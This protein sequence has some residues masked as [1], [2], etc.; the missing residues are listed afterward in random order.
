M[1]KATISL[2][3]I[4]NG[5]WN[6]KTRRHI[7]M[8]MMNGSESLETRKVFYIN[9]FSM[10]KNCCTKQIYTEFVPKGVTGR[11]DKEEKKERKI[12]NNNEIHHICVGTRHNKTH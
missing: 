9:T 7:K 4:P 12:E 6:G 10:F 1:Q 3:Q 2:N 11:S 8:L 5:D